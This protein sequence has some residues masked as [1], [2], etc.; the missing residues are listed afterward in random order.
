MNGRKKGMTGES[1]I[2]W[3]PTIIW[4]MKFKLKS[5]FQNYWEPPYYYY[6]IKSNS[7]ALMFNYVQLLVYFLSY[8]SL[9]KITAN[10]Q[11]SFELNHVL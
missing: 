6:R 8:D 9:Y 1:K 7:R 2:F 4:K 11:L 10:E 5:L 3:Q